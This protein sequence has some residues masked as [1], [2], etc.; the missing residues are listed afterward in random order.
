M[1]WLTF[2]SNAVASLAWPTALLV[3]VFLLRRELGNLVVTLRRLKWKELEAEFGQELKELEVAANRLPPAEPGQT[4]SDHTSA[5]DRTAG[6]TTVEALASVSPSA[7]LLTSWI[8]VEEAIGRAVRRLSISADAP[9]HL[10]PLRKIELLQE[11]TD[12]DQSTLAVLH[13]L[14]ELRNRAAHSNADSAALSSR[15]AIEYHNAAMRAVAALDRL[16]YVSRA[17]AFTPLD[18]PNDTPRSKAPTAPGE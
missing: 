14:R 1:D 12:L 6:M 9:W 2:L 10:S 8:T 11:W 18:V 4:V 13:R 3:V 15:D 16:Q 7:A 5:S 17:K